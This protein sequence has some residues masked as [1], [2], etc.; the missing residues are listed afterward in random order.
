MNKAAGK[1]N[2]GGWYHFDT[3]LESWFRLQ[4]RGKKGKVNTL[5]K[6]KKQQQF[7]LKTDVD[8]YKQHQFSQK[9]ML[10]CTHNISFYKIDVIVEHTT[11]IF[12]KSRCWLLE[13]NIDFQ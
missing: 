10:T 6:S 13:N 7:L 5:K 8:V 4:R 1:R 3:M 9:P 12:T 2:Q 11:S